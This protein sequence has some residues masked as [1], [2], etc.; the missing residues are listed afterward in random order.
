MRE[1]RDRMR[2]EKT[3]PKKKEKKKERKLK[4]ENIRGTDEHGNPG[5]MTSY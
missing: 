4:K 3:E 2:V 1:K 5:S